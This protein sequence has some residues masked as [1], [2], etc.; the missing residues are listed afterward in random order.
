MGDWE[1][2]KTQGDGEQSETGDVERPSR[3]GLYIFFFFGRCIYS[4]LLAGRP[5]FL[6][7]A[8]RTSRIQ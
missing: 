7:K 4:I 3:W 8:E 5:R 1:M 6:H 2:D